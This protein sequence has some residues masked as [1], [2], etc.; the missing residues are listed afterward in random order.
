MSEFTKEFI[1]A[2]RRCEGGTVAQIVEMIQEI[3]AEKMGA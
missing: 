3:R 1:E 2:V